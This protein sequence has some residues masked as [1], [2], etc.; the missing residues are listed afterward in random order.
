[1]STYYLLEA[2]NFEEVFWNKNTIKWFT[3][4]DKNILFFH[5]NVKIKGIKKVISRLIHKNN[6]IED[7]EEIEN[8]FFIHGNQSMNNGIK[9]DFIPLLERSQVIH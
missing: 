5:K 4:G 1:M 9:I 3:D 8:I 7:P 6:H 2:L